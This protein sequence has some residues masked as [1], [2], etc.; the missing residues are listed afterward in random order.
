LHNS[1]DFV[2]TKKQGSDCAGGG[3]LLVQHEISQHLGSDDEFPV[4][5]DQSQFPE[6]WLKN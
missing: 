3:V 2:F 1:T 5:F 4:V 6:L